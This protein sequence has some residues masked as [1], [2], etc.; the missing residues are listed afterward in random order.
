[1]L[2]NQYYLLVDFYFLMLFILSYLIL[3][4]WTSVKHV[5][6]TW[7]K[8]V[9][10]KSNEKLNIANSVMSCIL[11]CE[12]LVN[13]GDYYYYI[14]TQTFSVPNSFNLK[15]NFS[16]MIEPDLWRVEYF[17][18]LNPHTRQYIRNNNFILLLK[19][20]VIKKIIIA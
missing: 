14:F 16:L 18:Y 17:L 3:F 13:E 5:A 8:F 7:R 11:V 9:R 2:S 19:L 6:W 4:Y 20:L 10:W 1:M 12:S 15:Y